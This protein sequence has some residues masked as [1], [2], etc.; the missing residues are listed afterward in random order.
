MEYHDWLLKKFGPNFRAVWSDEA[1]NL[2]S[3][4]FNDASKNTSPNSGSYEICQECMGT[5][6]VEKIN[7]IRCFK[8]SGTGKHRITA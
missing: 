3:L 6:I 5:G 2:G 7:G 8:C 4:A 1:L